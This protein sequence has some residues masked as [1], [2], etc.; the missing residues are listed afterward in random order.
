MNGYWGKIVTVDLT[1]S[2]FTVDRV[3][4]SLFKKYLGG[5]G[6]AAKIIYDTLEPQVNP[7]DTRNII[8]FA[9]GPF[10]GTSVPGSG[11]WVAASK[12][13]LTGIWDDSTAGG[14][15]GP[16]FKRT[17]F[18]A[19]IIKG[20]AASPS[21]LWIHN[22]E[23]EVRDASGIW[24]L[25]TSETDK[26]IKSDLGDRKVQVACIGPAGEN[27]V[28]FASIVNE[29]G[30]AGRGG[31]G[32]VMGSKKLK[33]VA[34][35]GTMNL[36]VAEPDKLKEYSRETSRKMYEYVKDMFRKY[37]TTA[38][39]PKYID[40][41]GY[42]LTKYWGDG[43]ESFSP[44]LDGISGDSFLKITAS[45]IACTNCTIACHRHTKVEKPEKYSY[46][47]YGPEYETIAMF[48]WLNMISDTKAVGYLG[49]LCDEYGMDTISTASRIG[50][51]T[52][53]Y[54]RGWISK[55]ELNGLGMEWGNADTAA[56]LIHK[57]AKREG[58]GNILAEDIVNI[59]D[60][61]GHDAYKI[62]AHVKKMDFPAHDP[63]AFFPQL[64]NYVTG[65]RG[66]CHV[67]GAVLWNLL[68][69]LLP[70]WGVDEIH[71][72]HSMEKAAYVVA[73]YQNWSVIN[74]SLVQCLYM[75]LGGYQTNWLTEQIKF[76]RYVTG[77]NID[78]TSLDKIG[79][80]I[81]T[82]QRA[83]NVRF[84][85]SRKDDTPPPKVFEPM[86]TGKSKGKIPI[87]FEKT[88]MEY[89]E[90]RGWDKEGKPTVNKLIE[91]G[92]T[93]CLKPIWK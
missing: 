55:E 33:A 39:V 17:G 63:R 3:K 90:L 13:P 31:L 86:K 42:G 24:G 30:I 6:I 93:E 15:W 19:V 8:V 21:Y 74:N 87:P 20:K 32:A 44:I 68:G 78:N 70:E 4:E 83:I 72:Q 69:I 75:P 25:S 37:G 29:H 59:A 18:D 10:Q 73:K 49:Y 40:K 88:L 92:L 52:E 61:I 65:P 27:L 50:F 41:F 58:I 81:F 82:L 34:V 36:E 79:E 67:R 71:P 16:E 76:L 11:K 1:D 14:G 45:P 60:Y 46:D 22:G 80:R 64:I 57:I 5:A 23:V 38:S 47:G 28:K 7:L 12:S 62:I 26:A 2:I 56:I 91:L 43:L 66:A 84:G 85:V 9:V 89:Y 35:R 48:G 54:K 51:I 77:W 53:S